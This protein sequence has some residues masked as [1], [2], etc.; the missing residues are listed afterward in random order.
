VGGIVTSGQSILT[1]GNVAGV[2]IPLAKQVKDPGLDMKAVL[3]LPP[4]HWVSI[5]V[6]VRVTPTATLL[7]PFYG[8][9][10]FVPDYPGGPVPER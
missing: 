7:Q 2:S 6:M 10:D 3:R 8:P 5:K 4:H 9:M 1:I